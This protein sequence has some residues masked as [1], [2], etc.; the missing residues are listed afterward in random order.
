MKSANNS[1]TNHQIELDG[2]NVHRTVL[3]RWINAQIKSIGKAIDNLH[4][5]ISDGSVLIELVEKLSTKKIRKFAEDAQSKDDK[6][7]NIRIL[8][9]FLKAEH[10]PLE[11]ICMLLIQWYRY[12]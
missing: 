1:T 4:E 12:L 3:K 2:E 6:L 7:A 5:D 10:V 11:I 9:L 8:F